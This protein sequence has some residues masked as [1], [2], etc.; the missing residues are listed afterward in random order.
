[1]NINMN[2]PLTI[3]IGVIIGVIVTWVTGIVKPKHL[4]SWTEWLYSKLRSLF[5]KPCIS[6]PIVAI[7]LLFVGYEY[8]MKDLLYPSNKLVVALTNF[9]LVSGEEGPE[10]KALITHL[11]NSLKVY[12]HDIDVLHSVYPEV[13]DS[14]EA[15]KL[16]E[17]EKA[18]IVIWGAI[19]KTQKE[20][21][22]IPHITIVEDLGELKLKSQQL[23]AA[24]NIPLSELEKIQFR[25]RKAREI[26]DIILSV[27][28]LANYRVG[29]YEESIQIL[30]EIRYK[31]VDVLF[32]IGNGFLLKPKP[33]PLEAAVA[34]MRAVN[35]DS[36][37]EEAYCNWGFALNKLGRHGAAIEKYKRA[38]EINPDYV[39]A[40]LLWGTTLAELGRY[41]EEI[42]RYRTAIKIRPDYA[43][44]YYNWGLALSELGRF[45]EE[46][47][48]YDKATEIDP[49]FLKAY[50]NWGVALGELQQHKEAIQKYQ[51]VTEINPDYDKA[52]Y[53]WG[54]SL[55]HMG[56]I[57]EAIKKYRKSLRLNPGDES[58]YG[59]MGWEYYLKGDFHKCIELSEKAV[60]LDSSAISFRYNICLCYLRLGQ[61][62]KAKTLYS[63]TKK[64][65]E[66]LNKEMPQGAIDD[67][68]E[69]IEKDIMA[70]EARRILKEI[71]GLEDEEIEK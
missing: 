57:D 27:W 44:A 29:K 69:L 70:G 23:D 22:I 49:D 2:I 67:L 37:F 54:V 12:K 46:I 21:E 8:W 10:N 45:E 20:A 32:Y 5:K 24:I 13:R 19:E 6:I 51:K 14:M 61:A 40:Y 63:E 43:I 33:S 42:E 65:N 66:S 9:H 15:R 68:K 11:Q 30:K 48:M 18:H 31:D 58:S 38:T 52:Y 7:L 4:V 53:N 50:Y 59:N 56:Q 3:I 39:T 64:F 35:Q 36:M 26:T 28:G 41:E 60:E 47:E 17:K 71:F 34:Y 16:G 62:E 25:K 1:M 55:S